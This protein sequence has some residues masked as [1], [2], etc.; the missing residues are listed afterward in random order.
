MIG[1]AVGIVTEQANVG[2]K[3]SKE[4]IVH[5]SADYPNELCLTSRKTRANVGISAR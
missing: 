5:V 4:T 2:P 1:T 3:L